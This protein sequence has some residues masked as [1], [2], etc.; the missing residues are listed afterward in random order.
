MRSV[1]RKWNNL[2]GRITNLQAHT[3][4]FRQL[5]R[6]D[7][8][9]NLADHFFPDRSVIWLTKSR[10]IA[11][12]FIIEQ[13]FSMHPKGTRISNDTPICHPLWYLDGKAAIIEAGIMA[14]SHRNTASLWPT[15][16]RLGFPGFGSSTPRTAIHTY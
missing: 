5:P 10:S 1:L 14:A 6:P 11:I 7:H 4:C 16:Y 9:I 12:K 13:S 2:R 3:E 8:L 15:R